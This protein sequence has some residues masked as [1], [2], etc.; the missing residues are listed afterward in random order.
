MVLNCRFSLP[1]FCLLGCLNA[2]SQLT[3]DPV[4][5]PNVVADQASGTP[6]PE[7]LTTERAEYTMTAEVVGPGVFQAETGLLLDSSSSVRLVQAPSPLVRLGLTRRLELR[8][9]GDGFLWQQPGSQANCPR[10][11]GLSDMGFEVKWK[12]L[13]ESGYSPAL[14]IAPSISAPVGRPGFTSGSYNPTFKVA[15]TKSLRK[16]FRAS[17]N[18]NVSSLTEDHSRFLQSAASLCMEHN[19]PGG[20][21]AFW[22]NYDI[23]PTHYLGNRESFWNTGLFHAL[24]RNMQ[25]DIEVARNFASSTPP[26]WYLGA[27]F[28]IRRPH[29]LWAR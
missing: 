9:G 15:V 1:L 17:G 12:I 27:G 21:V 20:L 8:F 18:L 10:I 24:G 6:Q 4:A 28:V 7:S 19:L 14:A 11:S 3:P 13:D 25:I 2:Q 23:W 29:P 26:H 5:P 16:G 22:E